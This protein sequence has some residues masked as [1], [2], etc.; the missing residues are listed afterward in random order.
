MPANRDPKKLKFTI[1]IEIALILV[2]ASVAAFMGVKNRQ[3]QS[4]LPGLA[5]LPTGRDEAKILLATQPPPSSTLAAAHDEVVPARTRTPFP[6]PTPGPKPLCGGPP[7]MMILAVGI[8]NRRETYYYG[9][10]DVIRVVR[11]DFKDG[12]VDV[13]TL[14]R[15]LW[16]QIPGLDEWGISQGKLNQAYFYGSEYLGYY[17]GIGLGPG[18]MLETLAYNYNLGIEKYLS[19]NMRTVEKVIDAVGGID[20]DVPYDLNGVSEDPPVNLGYFHKGYQ[21]FNGDTAVRY[22]RVR[23]VDND[24]QRSKRQSIVLAALWK[25]MISPAILPHIPELVYSLHGSVETNL[26][27]KDLRQLTCLATQLSEEKIT[28]SGLP[29]EMLKEDRIQIAG[30]NKPA[31]YWNVDLEA[32]TR[33]LADFEVG[34]WPTPK[35]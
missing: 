27:A 13:L 33:L 20:I 10:A 28:F 8:D 11:V 30:H 1:F 14:P 31:F 12:S 35:P 15:D 17:Q 34:R 22:A 5:L 21:H 23:M 4:S 32:L 25:K 18:L 7:V 29:A 3:S 6:S 24:I 26:V 9:L 2:I 16:V 19:L